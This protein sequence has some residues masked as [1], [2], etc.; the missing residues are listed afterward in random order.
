MA[1]YEPKHVAAIR[2][3][4]NKYCA[5]W[6]FM[7]VFIY[8]T[9]RDKSHQVTTTTTTTTMTTTRIDV[10]FSVDAS[11]TY[12]HLIKMQYMNDITHNVLSMER[13]LKCRTFA[14]KT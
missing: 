11:S 13:K 4:T 9:Q 8:I 1:K 12:Q 6:V 2:F 10:T 5:R 3:L 7:G 14:A